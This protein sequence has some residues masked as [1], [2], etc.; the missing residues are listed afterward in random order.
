MNLLGNIIWLVFGGLAIAVEYFIGGLVLCLTIIGIPF[1]L[2][3]FKMGLLALFPFGQQT[4][5]TEQGSGMPQHPDEHPLVFRRGNLDRA[6]APVLGRAAL[7]HDHRHPVRPAA[8]Q[9]DESGLYSVWPGYCTGII[10]ETKTDRHDKKHD[11][12]GS[13]GAGALRLRTE[14]DEK[15]G[16]GDRSGQGRP[17]LHRI[18]RLPMVGGA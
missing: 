5:V 13:R 6:V 15:N 2:Q 14:R 12:H 9:T 3:A 18:G 7:H 16:A 4:V 11:F 8:F 10:L 1:G 17:R